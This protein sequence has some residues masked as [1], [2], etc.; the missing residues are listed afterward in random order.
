MHKKNK[1]SL[2]VTADQ[3]DVAFYDVIIDRIQRNQ[4]DVAVD[5]LPRLVDENGV[6]CYFYETV[7]DAIVMASLRDAPE[8]LKAAGLE[9]ASVYVSQIVD[10]KRGYSIGIHYTGGIASASNTIG[11]EAGSPVT[12]LGINVSRPHIRDPRYAAWIGKV[13]GAGFPV[14]APLGAS[15]KGGV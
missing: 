15:A 11:H 1:L 14:V 5:P 4:L 7:A 6:V 10:P 12:A 8:E 9:D 2:P 3:V 13:V